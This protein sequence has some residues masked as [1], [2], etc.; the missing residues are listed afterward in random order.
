MS[1][2]TVCLINFFSEHVHYSKLN[3]KVVEQGDFNKASWNVLISGHPDYFATRSHLLLSFITY[4]LLTFACPW[5]K[6]MMDWFT[7]YPSNTRSQAMVVASSDIV[8]NFKLFRQIIVDLVWCRLPSLAWYWSQQSE[9]PWGRIPRDI[10]WQ[11][12][13]FLWSSSRT[14]R[15]NDNLRRPWSRYNLSP[16]L[17]LRHIRSYG[18]I[19]HLVRGEMLKVPPPLRFQAT[20]NGEQEPLDSE[21]GKK[22][23]ALT[24]LA[25][26]TWKL[27][28][29][30]RCVCLRLGS[31]SFRAGGSCI[32]R[33]LSQ[34]RDPSVIPYSMFFERLDSSPCLT[35]LGY[36]S[37]RCPSWARSSS[38]LS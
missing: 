25:K 21:I 14:S 33:Y 37:K 12:L 20:W 31:R 15:T 10:R 1:K 17:N 22:L 7:F 32:H 24:V 9:C 13:L 18:C 35:I 29:E 34:N 28:R 30:E 16:R 36:S 23:G 5:R 26:V 19:S 6:I 3:C 27:P 8:T 4:W 11:S 38:C 2:L